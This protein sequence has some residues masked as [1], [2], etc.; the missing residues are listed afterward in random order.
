LLAAP[1][2]EGETHNKN[3]N[4]NTKHN[5]HAT[6]TTKHSNKQAQTNALKQN[7]TTKHT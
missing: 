2:Q 5:K 6:Q 7:K 3:N 1:S 4:N